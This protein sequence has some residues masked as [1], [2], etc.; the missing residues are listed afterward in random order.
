M[1]PAA[2]KHTIRNNQLHIRRLALWA[3]CPL[4]AL[5]VGLFATIQKTSTLDQTQPA[6]AILLLGAGVTESG[7]PSN[8]LEARIDHAADLYT[9]GYAP[10]IAVTG[11]SKHGRGSEAGAAREALIERGVPAEA[12]LIEEHSLTTSQNLNYIS[13]ILSENDVT[14]VLLVSSSYHTWRGRI[15]AQDAGLT[16]YLAPTLDPDEVYPFKRFRLITREVGA[17]ILYFV[18]GL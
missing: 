15:I 10:L 17:S 13:P 14:S 12:I 4:I 18:F 16:V 3:A 11:G 2:P 9:E 8:I 1:R 7:E 6:D 5:F